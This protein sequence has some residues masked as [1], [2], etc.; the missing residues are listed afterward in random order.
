MT[1]FDN[2]YIM[3]G[4]FYIVTEDPQSIPPRLEL[5]SLG[6][7]M[8]NSEEDALTN[9]PTEEHIKIIGIQEAARLFGTGVNRFDGVTFMQ[10]GKTLPSIFPLM[11]PQL[12]IFSSQTTGNSSSTSSTLSLKSPHTSTGVS[13]AFSTLISLPPEPPNFLS[14]NATSSL[15]PTLSLG[16]IK[17][18]ST[19]FSSVAHSLLALYTLRTFGTRSLPAGNHM[20]L[21]ES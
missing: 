4:V 6:K 15:I 14:R 8:S 2:L 9:T 12:T 10:T 18:V 3:N 20:S 1:L 7:E 13:I 21:I 19:F 16:K 5:M 17:P 11:N